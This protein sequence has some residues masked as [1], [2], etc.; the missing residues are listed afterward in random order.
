MADNVEDVT[1]EILKGIQASITTLNERVG[2]LSEEFGRRFE[3][4]EAGCERT[5]AMSLGCS[6]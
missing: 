5:G 6:S 1:H 3:H 4:L 2:Q